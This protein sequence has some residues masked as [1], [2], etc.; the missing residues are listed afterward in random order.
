MTMTKQLSANLFIL[1]ALVAIVTGFMVQSNHS[2]ATFHPRP[3]M[4]IDPLWADHF[5]FP[6][7][8]PDGDG[9]Y[10]AQ[11]F[12]ENN[13]L[14]DDW[15]G[16]G[17]GNTDLGDT[18]YSMA[19][20]YLISAKDN[21]H[22]WG[23]VIMIQHYMKGYNKVNSLYAH[24][25]EMFVSQPNQLIRRGDPIGSI[26]TAGGIYPAHLHFEMRHGLEL[27]LGGGYSADTSGY[28]D[29]TAF[30]NSHR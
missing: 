14:G 24:C 26:G 13:H 29:P 28:L 27:P 1:F 8:K 25:T 19:N 15:N 20:G 23:N 2:M 4:E 3:L 7:G 18:I 5:D 21:G 11:K 6:V 16:L 30:I 12:G 17:G 9:Y 10:N 22:G